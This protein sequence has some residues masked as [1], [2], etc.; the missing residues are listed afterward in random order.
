MSKRTLLL[1]VAAFIAAFTAILVKHR[2]SE[3]PP[4]QTA[5]KARVL[6]ARQDL[7]PGS[8]AQAADLSW[9]PAPDV[10]P[11]PGIAGQETDLSKNVAPQTA[12]IYE[13]TA[14]LEDFNGAVV[15]EQVHAGDPIPASALMKAGAGGL[16]S[17][18][19]NPGMRAVSIGVTPNSDDAPFVSGFV[20]PGDHVDLI[21]T[22]EFNRTL[23]NGRE[24]ES[25]KIVFSKIFVQNV[26]VLAV[27][28]SLDNPDNKAI[29][30]K[31]VTVEVTPTQAQEIAVASELGKISISLRSAVVAGSAADQKAEAAALA[32]SNVSDSDIDGG[33]K[34]DVSMQ[35]KVYRPK[36]VQNLDFYGAGK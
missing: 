10:A 1:L 36:E 12:Y 18:V 33:G 27:D 34:S 35:V 17:A 5:Q 8:F 2:L 31:T 9:G 29:V 7:S 28:Q 20:L 13:G 26:R 30:A 16:L 4:V 32:Q 14:K 23:N 15:R 22:R 25:R 6:I 19:L 3:A 21:V 24:Q 11:P